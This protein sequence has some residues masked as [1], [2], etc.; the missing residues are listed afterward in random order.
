[1]LATIAGM[2]TGVLLIRNTDWS[3]Q[4]MADV[5]QYAYVPQAQLH[6]DMLPVSAPLGNH[7]GHTLVKSCAPVHLK[8]AHTYQNVVVL[9]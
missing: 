2:N 1:M 6:D 8:D 5:G 9:V 3:R 4:Y 7:C